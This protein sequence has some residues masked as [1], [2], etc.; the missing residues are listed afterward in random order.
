M[1]LEKL[2]AAA[3]AEFNK[4]KV[5]EPQTPDVPVITSSETTVVPP[6]VTLPATETIPKHKAWRREIDCGDGAGVQ[7]FEGDTKDELIEALSTAQL[8]A[9]KK[10]RE[11]NRRI[12]ERILP[13]AAKAEV[14]F[15]PT[16]LTVDEQFAISQELQTNPAGAISK[17]FKSTVGVTPEELREVLAESRQAA[18][19]AQNQREG[20]KF[21][22]AHPEYKDDAVNGK[23]MMEYLQKNNMAATAS[24]Y[25]IAFDALTETGLVKVHDQKEVTAPPEKVLRG[26]KAHV[27][28]SPR[29]SSAD[30]VQA[31]PDE[32]T[33]ESMMKLSP[34]ERR[35]IVLRSTRKQ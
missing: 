22:N 34:D 7:V 4:N 23:A 11:Q 29:Q 30:D 24:N 2:R 14:K 17:L 6:T 33:V 13:E 3:E 32:P 21:V 27:G 20:A 28:I 1:D 26:K 9:T 16:A 15:E 19:Q 18:Q 5:A 35:R 8:N 10:I 31:E 12:K 25:E